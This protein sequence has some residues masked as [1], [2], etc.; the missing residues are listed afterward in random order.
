MA[1]MNTL[2]IISMSSWPATHLKYYFVGKIFEELIFIFWTALR[3]D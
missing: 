1:N 3:K 2:E